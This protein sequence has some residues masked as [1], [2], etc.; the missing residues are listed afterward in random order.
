MDE[1]NFTHLSHVLTQMF[2]MNQQ[3]TLSLAAM[4]ETLSQTQG[5]EEKYQHRLQ[6]LKSGELG[7]KLSQDNAAFAQVL[8]SVK[9]RQF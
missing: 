9:A 8:R 6:V 2:D 4:K 5:F 1:I 7:K 3:L